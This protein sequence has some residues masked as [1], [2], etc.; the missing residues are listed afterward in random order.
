MMKDGQLFR[1]IDSNCWDPNVR[2]KDMEDTGNNLWTDSQHLTSLII[3]TI[4]I[5]MKV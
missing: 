2:I 5:I 4:I 1:V 3:V